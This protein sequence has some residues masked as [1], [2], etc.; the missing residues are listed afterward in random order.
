MPLKLSLGLTEKHGLPDYGSIAASCH[1]EIELEST[2]LR[3]DLDDFHRQVRH[4]RCA[5]SARR[6]ACDGEDEPVCQ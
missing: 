4:A 3:N 6:T 1:V 2:L 5:T